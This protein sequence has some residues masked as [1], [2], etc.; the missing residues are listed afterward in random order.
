MPKFIAHDPNSVVRELD[1]L[2]DMVHKGRA[3]VRHWN[4]STNNRQ[5]FETFDFEIVE[6][7]G[8]PLIQGDPE[9]KL[10]YLLYRAINEIKHG[11]SGLNV[12]VTDLQSRRDMMT[13]LQEVFIQFTVVNTGHTV[14]SISANAQS[15][16]QATKAAA[17]AMNAFAKPMID[18]DPHL[19]M[20]L[21]DKGVSIEPIVAYRD[22][23]V[24]PHWEDGP[25]L[26][27]R[28]GVA[29]DAREKH[30][31]ICTKSNGIFGHD[32]PHVGCACGVYAF[33]N[34]DHPDMVSSDAHV[35]AEIYLWGEVLI[36]ETGYRA[37][38]AY[39]KTLFL[40]DTGTK[41]IRWVADQLQEQYGVPCL[42]MTGEK[43]R[44]SHMIDD[45]LVT[46]LRGGGE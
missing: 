25:L 13:G 38:F 33:T 16:T 3:V 17:A 44:L 15:F 32:A 37:Q 45:A 40:R 12:G 1:M 31:A 22:F 35:W 23:V 24:S 20:E 26:R 4:V 14:A 19:P 42:L 10:L 28:N 30:H 2:G 46:L 21:K 34:P 29:W 9:R 5:P 43:K 6:T 18:F 41:V 39:P 8:G 36:C 27:S 7:N 11:Y